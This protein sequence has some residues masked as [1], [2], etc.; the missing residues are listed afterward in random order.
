MGMI[1]MMPFFRQITGKLSSNIY[2]SLQGSSTPQQ[3][4]FLRD[5]Q[6]EMS[7]NNSLD[8]PFD[9]LNVAVF[10]LETTGFYPE[11]GDQIISIGAIKMKGHQIKEHET[12]YSLVKADLPLS[13][14]ISALTNIQET[15][16]C[17]APL[18]SD[19]L[20]Q[21]FKFVK[22]D[23]LVAHHSKHEHSFMRKI[24]WDLLRTKFNHRLVDTSFLIRLS[25]L[26]MKS[27]SL[28]EVCIQCGIDIRDR[29]HALGD[30]IMTAQVWRHYLQLAQQ[31][32]FH[33]LR[34]VYDYLAKHD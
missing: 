31:K 18:A 20:V 27:A 34:E 10:D 14:E 8:T 12:F 1:V 33:H 13:E 21:F 5:L 26:S 2:A 16:L 23:T 19:V 11:K 29:H 25:D 4:A 9:E 15:E 6:R 28:E 3:I 17:A 24:T 22:S 7:Q 30:A 32:G